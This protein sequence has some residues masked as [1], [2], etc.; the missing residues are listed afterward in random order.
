MNSNTQFLF[1]NGVKMPDFVAENLQYETLMGSKAYGAQ[2]SDKADL[3][4]YGWTMPSVEIIFP[5]RFGYV[6][7][8]TKDYQNF[9]QWQQAHIV[10]EGREYDMNIYN[11]TKFFRLV[12]DGNPNMVDA[13]FTEPEHKTLMTRLGKLV[14]DNR[15]VF[16]SKHVTTKAMGFAMGEWARLKRN[17]KS[18]RSA[19]RPELV[20][21]YGYDTKAAYHTYRLL[22]QAEEYMDTGT[23]H[24]Y[25]EKRAKILVS[26][27]NG[28]W[29][30]E[31]TN[32]TMTKMFSRI[33]D[34]LKVSTHPDNASEAKVVDLLYSVLEEFYG[35][36]Y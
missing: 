8:F 9:S 3:D 36:V 34:K 6:R 29:S 35:Y 30:L 14:Y 15:S 4:F 13:L 26:I 1:D 32:K 24:V 27:R 2:V 17:G 25:D 10:V 12:A 19:N 5:H 11:V 33:E 18:S 28:E 22:S 20:A 7:G 21:R 31:K 16:L 23:I